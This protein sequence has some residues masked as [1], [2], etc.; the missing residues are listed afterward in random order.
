MQPPP[1]P[2]PPETLRP[3][4]RHRIGQSLGD[5]RQKV[6]FTVLI[7]AI[8]GAMV[9]LLASTLNVIPLV[10]ISILI[11]VLL[12]SLADPLAQVLPLPARWLVLVL[13][14]GLAVL[15]TGFF[16]FAG[17]QVADQFDALGE[18][19]PEAIDDVEDGLADLGWEVSLREELE[20]VSASTASMNVFTRLSGFFSGIFGVITNLALVVVAGIYMAFEP[21]LYIRNLVRLFP[22]PMRERAQDV[23]AE[24]YNIV[25][26]WLIARL[27][28]M[29]VVGILTFI[30]L[31]LVGMPLALTLA[32][33][34]GLLS[35]I[36]N[37]GPTL[38]AVPAILVGFTESP[39]MALLVAGVYVVVQ[40]IENYLITPNVQRSTVQLPPALVMLSQVFLI[41]VFGW[42]GLFIAAPLVAFGIVLVKSVY[43]ED[44]LG[45]EV[46]RVV[47]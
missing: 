10:F 31:T 42:L 9:L 30:G 33:I 7:V 22:I 8:V 16:I 41:L 25:R 47:S 14:L 45:D 13:A 34:A 27:I 11:A 35:F 37:I 38:S 43:V 5:F 28:S 17:P 36:P 29:L 44:C 24:G 23:L 32:I 21:P 1:P 4:P 20:Q 18:S 26:R 19:V 3:T 12:R 6:T 39:G 2:M 46:G 40:L 15:V